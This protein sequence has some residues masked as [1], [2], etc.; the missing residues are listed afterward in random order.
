MRLKLRAALLLPI[1]LQISSIVTFPS[2]A[3]L[4]FSLSSIPCSLIFNSLLSSADAVDTEPTQTQTQTETETETTSTAVSV[5]SLNLVSP[6]VSIASVISHH[7]PSSSASFSPSPYKSFSSSTLIYLTPWN[8]IGFTHA[9]TYSCKFDYISPVWFQIKILKTGEKK[10]KVE[11]QGKHDVKSDWIER[12]RENSKSKV[13]QLQSSSSSAAS[14]NSS[15]CVI[16]RIVPR[17]IVE[18]SDASIY[19]SL[20]TSSHLQ[21]SIITKVKAVID[22]YQL[23]GM[24]LEMAEAWPVVQRNDPEK[25]KKLNRFITKMA[26]EIRKKKQ[27]TESSAS[28]SS[29]TS[30][31]D[32]SSRSFILVVRPHFARSTYFQHLD[33]VDTQSSIDGYSLMTYDF[34]S[35]AAQPGPNSPMEWMISSVNTL[36]GREKFRDVDDNLKKKVLMGLNFYG[37]K[38]E[39]PPGKKEIEG[40]ATPIVGHELIKLLSENE[41]SAFFRWDKDTLEHLLRVKIAEGEKKGTD[42]A[43]AY[44]TLMS[45]ASRLNTA[46][47]LGTGVSIWEGGQGLEYFMDLF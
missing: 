41:K 18:V 19:L 3:S 17:F 9:E 24:V 14:T 21:T 46:K 15:S 30:S 32:S 27:S 7:S 40:G 29:S 42:V 35:S 34:S 39:K 45:L 10:M 20:A 8:S 37:I 26:K 31:S 43:V 4:S 5:H 16:P 33:F 12:V 36:I 47:E 23:D 28:S 2:H 38:W 22:E 13:L 1:L 44:P 11:V 25:R 6:Q